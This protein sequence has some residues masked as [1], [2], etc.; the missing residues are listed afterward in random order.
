MERCLPL[1]DFPLHYAT[2]ALGIQHEPS[3]YNCHGNFFI[4]WERGIANNTADLKLSSQSLAAVTSR[5]AAETRKTG[6]TGLAANLNIK[7]AES[8]LSR[9]TNALGDWESCTVDT[10]KCTAQSKLTFINSVVSS[11]FQM[12]ECFY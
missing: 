7:T 5:S 10:A 12:F 2:S 9:A 11:H 4:A 6:R 3:N 1:H 8:E